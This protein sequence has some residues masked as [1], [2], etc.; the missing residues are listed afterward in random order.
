MT[1]TDI[2]QL[3][4]KT[5]LNLII[6]VVAPGIN[7]IITSRTCTIQVY[8]PAL[9][10]FLGV[11]MKCYST[12]IFNLLWPMRDQECNN[13]KKKEFSGEGMGALVWVPK[14]FATFAWGRCP[15]ISQSSC[16]LDQNGDT[17]CEPSTGMLMLSLWME[18][19]RYFVRLSIKLFCRKR[20]LRL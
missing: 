14:I 2:L 10:W 9:Q 6:K 11:F 17:A 19:I 4:V 12:H 15:M 20:V 18:T 16:V 1:S 13:L 8:T 5:S 7:I 3:V